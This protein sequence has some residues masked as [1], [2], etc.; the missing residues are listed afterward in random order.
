MNKLVLILLAVVFIGCS[1]SDD[2]NETPALTP[3][4]ISRG[5]LYGAG[6]EGIEES[7]LLITNVAD[8]N[9]LKNSMDSVNPISGGFT[10]TTIDFQNYDVIAIF[11]EIKGYGGYT[12][13]IDEITENEDNYIVS[14]VH[15]APSGFATTVI[16]QPYHIYKIPKATKPV[17]FI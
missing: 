3:T 1:N 11:D 10:E 15:T 13:A 6:D 4:E 5:D 2:N 12:I 8:W 17:I 14:I 16:T 9:A 7:R